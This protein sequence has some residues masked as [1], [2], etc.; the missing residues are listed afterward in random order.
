MS[1]NVGPG[2]GWSGH[3]ERWIECLQEQVAMLLLRPPSLLA[4]WHCAARHPAP[5]CLLRRPLFFCQANK[6]RG[7]AARREGRAP[8]IGS[9][10]P[11]NLPAAST[12]RYRIF[13]VGSASGAASS[14]LPHMRKRR[15]VAGP[16]PGCRLRAGLTRARPWPWCSWCRLPR[17]GPASNPVCRHSPQ[18]ASARRIRYRATCG[19]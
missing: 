8:C 7:G 15:P 11:D 19:R 3:K 6:D 4:S 14:S 12:R 16:P 10:Y 2:S 17:H 5:S 18:T 9:A 1:S 13:R